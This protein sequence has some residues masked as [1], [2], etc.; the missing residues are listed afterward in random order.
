VTA[1][2]SRES[3]DR[4]L[5]LPVKYYALTAVVGLVDFL[6][7]ATSV[8][9][10]LGRGFSGTQVGLV[11]AGG[12]LIAALVEVPSGAWG[13]KFG[14][15]LVA[16]AGLAT[17]GAGLVVFAIGSAFWIVL[18]S[19]CLWAGGAAMHSG[20]PMSLV[21]NVLHSTDRSEAVPAVIRRAQT[22]RWVASTVGAVAAIGLLK[23]LKPNVVIMLGGVILVVTAGW[24]ARA[25]PDVR[26]NQ[27]L[28]S[29]AFYV[30]S[31]LRLILSR[32]LTVLLLISSFVSVPAA[33]MMVSWQPAGLSIAQINEKYL[34]LVF[35]SYS[36]GAA[37]G[38]W[39]SK[40]SRVLVSARAVFIM[41]LLMLVALFAA[42]T[43]GPAAVV[44]AFFAAEV[45]SGALLT[46]L[47]IVQQDAFPSSL[48]NTLTSGFSMCAALAWSISSLA[49]GLAWHSL[50]I[51]GALR[52]LP[53]TVIV[54]VGLAA[55]SFVVLR[56]RATVDPN[57]AIT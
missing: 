14:L 4:D 36:L 9:V 16:A 2:T 3:S 52:W 18:V 40:L 55:L 51:H 25:W 28:Q 15:R 33:I 56:P 24:V 26:A 53:L 7:G 21:V 41:S 57:R 44:I 43:V 12:M 54:I 8:A 17:W 22:T 20:A 47:A 1:R 27:R 29:T 5:L 49:F 10:L 48:R 50:G 34:P 42:T 38:A 23:V 30:R 19:L 35:L 31:A 45:L 46:S 6:F 32:N 39:L 11:A 13:D 37:A